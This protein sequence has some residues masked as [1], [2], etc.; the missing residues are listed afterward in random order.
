MDPS[1]PLLGP[2]GQQA[3]GLEAS[4]ARRQGGKHAQH[5][6]EG[7][8]PRAERWSP[9]VPALVGL[10]KLLASV[11]RANQATHDFVQ[12]MIQSAQRVF[13]GICS[14]ALTLEEKTRLTI[15]IYDSYPVYFSV[16]NDLYTW[17]EP[18]FARRL[19]APPAQ[20]LVGACGTGREAVALAARGYRVDALEPA[21]DFVDESR[22]RLGARG[23]VYKLSYEELSAV[24]LDGKDSFEATPRGTRYD[25]VVLGSGSMTHV[26]D[27][28]EQERLLRSM[29]RLCPQGPI[30]ASFFCEPE[31]APVRA[32]RATRFGR[33][34]GRALARLRFMSPAHCDRLSYRAHSGF[35]YTFTPR[36][37]E[38]LASAI[39]RPLAWENDDDKLRPFHYAT[40]LAP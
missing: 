12:R 11:H 4:D 18:W 14:E 2:S 32:G 29:C 8:S 33:S 39:G 17:E 24:V 25:A 13:G 38:R 5:P 20:V 1:T 22:R 15:R 36:E 6:G 26:L 19:P 30:L 37:I 21:P 27:P 40:F 3:N 10:Y 23:N 28:H 16:G 31:E 35:A 34:M 7:G 9:I